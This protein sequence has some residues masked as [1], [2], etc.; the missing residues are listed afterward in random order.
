MATIKFLEIQHMLGKADIKDIKSQVAPLT[1]FSFFLN[2]YYIFGR[3]GEPNANLCFNPNSV[4]SS[5]QD[6]N[7]FAKAA[8]EAL[9]KIADSKCNQAIMLDFQKHC[10]EAISMYGEA[11]DYGNPVALYTLAF[12]QM[13]GVCGVSKDE[14]KA[15]AIYQQLARKKYAPALNELGSEYLRGTTIAK[16]EKQAFDLLLQATEQGQVTSINNLG[17]LYRDGIGVVADQAKALSLFEQAAKAGSELAKGNL[18]KLKAKMA[19]QPP[20]ASP[21]PS[22][23][24]RAG[25]G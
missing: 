11:A 6:E 9:A 19:Q 7:A 3:P 5:L 1:P 21:A 2:R 12:Y 14:K 4:P 15:I 24:P 10:S 8:E 18:T 16:D 23:P 22:A 13:H 25:L 20:S 17:V